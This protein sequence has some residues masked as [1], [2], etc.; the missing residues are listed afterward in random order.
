LEFLAAWPFVPA[1]HNHVAHPDRPLPLFGCQVKKSKKMKDKSTI[2]TP[3]V[4]THHILFHCVEPAAAGPAACP[5]SLLPADWLASK[6]R[7]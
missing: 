4:P 7:R 2:R 1:G 5:R 3:P 6:K